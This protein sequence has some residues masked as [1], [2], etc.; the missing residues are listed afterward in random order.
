MLPIHL[1]GKM[2][3]VMLFGTRRDRG[4]WK[5]TTIRLLSA[6]RERITHVLERNL[7]IQQLSESREETLR[8]MGLVL[9][10]RDYE[11]KGHT[12]RVVDLSLKLGV[13]LG[14][15]GEMLD[16]LRWG[17]YLHDTGKIAIPDH[18]LLK[19]GKLTT[20]EFEQV[21]KHQRNWL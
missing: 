20:E 2:H 6:V 8:A 5:D 9:E 21:K 16:A 13:K 18:I 19:P 7:Y 11:T 3:G 15:K 1:A 4:D 17:A 12:D 10:Y 14:L